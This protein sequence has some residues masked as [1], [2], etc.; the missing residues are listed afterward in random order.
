MFSLPFQS[1]GHLMQSHCSPTKRFVCRNV[2]QAGKQILSVTSL[3]FHGLLFPEVLA[4]NIFFFT[5]KQVI[6]AIF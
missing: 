1:V 4:A 3:Q 6:L 2:L 5:S